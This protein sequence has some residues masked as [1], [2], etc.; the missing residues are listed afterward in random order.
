M[1]SKE[2]ISYLK[3]VLTS[4]LLLEANEELV[5]TNRYRSSL[6]QQI[7]RT[8]KMLEPIVREEFD[9]VYAADP[10]M[11]TNLLNKIDTVINIIAKLDLDEIVIVEDMLRDYTSNKEK[12]LK[13]AQV[14][15]DKI[16]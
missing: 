4:Q 10:E 3:T 14:K 15:I 9:S 6:K 16:D 13:E 5:L 2:T 7:N 12:Y 8:N 11:T 1:V